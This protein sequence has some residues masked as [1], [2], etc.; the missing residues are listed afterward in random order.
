MK[1]ACFAWII[2]LIVM[3]SYPNSSASDKYMDIQTGDELYACNC[4]K[5]CGCHSMAKVPGNCTCGKEMV[6]ARVVKAGGG[7][8]ILISDVW[9]RMRIFKMIGNYSCEKCG[10]VSQEP[11]N[12]CCGEEMK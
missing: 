7:T 3:G 4:G 9:G 6:K 12:C 2:L 1:R 10:M 5:D 8:A 11:G